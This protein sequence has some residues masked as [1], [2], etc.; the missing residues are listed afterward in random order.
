MFI[1]HNLTQL[2]CKR[3]L[4]NAPSR[5]N[6][7]LIRVLGKHNSLP[8]L[9]CTT[10]RTFR[11]RFRDA[12]LHREY[13]DTS[14]RSPFAMENGRSGHRRRFGTPGL[15]NFVMSATALKPVLSNNREHAAPSLHASWVHTHARLTLN[16]L[17]GASSGDIINEP[18]LSVHCSGTRWHGP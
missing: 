12:Q 13:R 2:K 3:S 15:R 1:G 7:M 5:C 6:I 8:L 11:S 16:N 9:Q 10:P 14:R 4:A 18:A 17:C